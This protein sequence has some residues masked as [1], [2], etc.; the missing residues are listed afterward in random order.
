MR[1]ATRFAYG[2]PRNPRPGQHLRGDCQVWLF[3][4]PARELVETKFADVAPCF[5]SFHSRGSIR[6]YSVVNEL[7]AGLISRARRAR[8]PELLLALRCARSWR[9]ARE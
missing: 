6:G 7:N 9:A 3:A 8:H 1:F 4:L 5:I 2:N